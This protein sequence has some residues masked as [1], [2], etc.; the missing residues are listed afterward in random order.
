MKLAE[1]RG[2]TLF[3]LTH[4][5]LSHIHPGFQEDVTEASPHACAEPFT[6]QCCVSLYGV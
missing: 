3:D 1:D 4:E 6:P 5:D 2:C